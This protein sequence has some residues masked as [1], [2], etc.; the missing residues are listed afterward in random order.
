MNEEESELEKVDRANPPTLE[1]L[2]KRLLTMEKEHKD[3]RIIGDGTINFS[4]DMK[5]GFSASFNG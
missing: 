5:K 3:F 4:G 2:H 1:E